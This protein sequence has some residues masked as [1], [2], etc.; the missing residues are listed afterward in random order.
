M[1]RSRSSLLPF[2]FAG[3]SL[4]A[5]GIASA[6]PVAT[7]EAQRSVNTRVLRV[8]KAVKAI[9]E[10][11]PTSVP[12]A[13]FK[14]YPGVPTNNG[15]RITMMG[16]GKFQMSSTD[17]ATDATFAL[18]PRTGS[19]GSHVPGVVTMVVPT[20]IDKLYV[21]DC[22]VWWP[23]PPTP[24]EV[25]FGVYGKIDP[26]NVVVD[27]DHA[28]FAFKAS[29]TKSTVMMRTTVVSPL[30]FRSCEITKVD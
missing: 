30:N 28:I 20:Q 22:N 14:L 25:S 6:G 27:D 19:D 4:L 5:A 29:E 17:D 7:P 21:F 3:L 15:A 16:N 23:S 18:F 8:Q 24:R 10:A 12:A 13:Q 2:G 26:A 11:A 1:S 9:G